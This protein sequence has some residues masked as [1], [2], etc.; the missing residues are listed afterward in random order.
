MCDFNNNSFWILRKT[1]GLVCKWF[2]QFSSCVQFHVVPYFVILFCDVH[3][4]AVEIQIVLKLRQGEFGKDHMK[5][6]NSFQPIW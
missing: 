5:K 1:R 3:C 4:R 2:Q 6:K